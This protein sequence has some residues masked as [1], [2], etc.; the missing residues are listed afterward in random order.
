MSDV[1]PMLVIEDLADAIAWYRDALGF[2]VFPFGHYADGSPRVAGAKLEDA[3]FLLSNDEA[4]SVD[5]ARGS[6]GIRLYFHLDDSIDT[7]YKRWQVD[8]RV[9]VVDVPRDQDW[10][11]R[12]LIIRDPWGNLLIFSNPA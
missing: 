8:P 1:Q 12:T 11:D 2:Q 10:G 9:F 7:L 3:F 4:L 5:D 6:G